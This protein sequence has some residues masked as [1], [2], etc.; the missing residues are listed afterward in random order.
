MPR[1]A[2]ATADPQLLDLPADILDYLSYNHLDSVNFFNFRLSC[3]KVHNNTFKAF[4]RR[5]FKHVKFMLA[6]HSLA[7]LEAISKDKQLSSFI[8][9]VGIGPERLRSHPELAPDN[10]G[11]SLHHEACRFRKVEHEKLLQEQEVM[12]CD[13]LDLEILTK[14]F[15][16]LPNLESIGIGGHYVA[17]DATSR[18]CNLDYVQSWGIEHMLRKLC[19]F[20]GKHCPSRA[21][22]FCDLDTQYRAFEIVFKV[23]AL[24]GIASRKLTLDLHIRRP[25]SWMQ[26]VVPFLLSDPDVH[27]ALTRTWRLTLETPGWQ[28]QPTPP[29]MFQSHWSWVSQLLGEVASSL[30]SIKLY[31]PWPQTRRWPSDLV[32]GQFVVR[33]YPLLTTI[34]LH[35]IH[36]DLGSL[37]RLLK[38]QSSTAKTIKF[39]NVVITR[40]SPGSPPRHDRW[41]EV[42]EELQSL[43]MLKTLTLSRVAEHGL[44]PANRR[45]SDT[46]EDQTVGNKGYDVRMT[47]HTVDLHGHQE[48]IQVLAQAIQDNWSRARRILPRALENAGS[49]WL[50]SRSFRVTVS[51]TRGH[52]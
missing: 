29:G 23:L 28:Q 32:F 50:H 7:A 37:L 35:H 45:V 27:A 42:F 14:A 3:R 38:H 11:P 24:P 43:Q 33:N 31:Y 13:G 36:V 49:T 22:M 39:S 6:P 44:L 12:E 51:R 21:E 4:G 48:I 16:S 25:I 40:A 8:R 19:V 1:M 52:W 26:G 15:K 2:A 10:S 47:V 17:A 46:A 20:G 41:L 18:E 9:H 30:N 5:Y 34:E